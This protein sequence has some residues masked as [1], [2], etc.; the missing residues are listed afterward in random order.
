MAPHPLAILSAQETNVARDVIVASYPGKVIKFRE[1]YLHEPPKAQLKEF[2]ILEHSARLSPTSPRPA[3]LA[4]CQYDVIG[5][6]VEYHE[7]LVDVELKKRVSHQ[8]VGEPFRA[9]LSGYVVRFRFPVSLCPLRGKN[10]HRGVQYR[11]EFEAVIESCDRSELFK[12]AMSDFTLPE[13]F[14]IVI[15]PWP[16]GPLDYDEDNRRY[17]QALCFARDTRSRNPDAN[18]YSFPL[19]LIPVMD[20]Q[21][22]EI[23]RVD[24]PAT[25][26]KGDGLRDQTFDR[27]ILAHTKPSEYVPEL[28]PQGTRKDLKELN[29][30]QPEGP[31]FRVIDESLVEWQKWRFRVAFNPRE[32]ATIHDVWYD[33]RS[34]LYRLSVSEMVR[35][36][37]AMLLMTYTV[38][39]HRGILQTVPYAD[40]RPPFHRKQAFDFGD[41]GGGNMANNL[42]LGCDCLGLIKYF[43]AVV[44][45]T[46]GTARNFPNVICMHEQD[47]GIGNYI[48]P[49]TISMQFHVTTPL[50]N[51]NDRLETYELAH[52]SGSRHPQ[53]G[54]GYPIHHHARKL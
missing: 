26:G 35:L 51:T 44:T 36:L 37:V 52:W 9:S 25:G 5:C 39:N 31:S 33:G 11:E 24:R 2:L 29:V 43:D 3:R 19:P 21:T 7:S 14:D 41:G 48:N 32:G 12:K 34:V 53:P 15:E 20:A 54:T 4:L 10:A 23:I 47:N 13:G 16:Y 28:L 50:I 40:P 8:V 18:F 22:R 38:T 49:C 6:E 46:D 17:F 27:N 30:V 42:S 1:I 45:G